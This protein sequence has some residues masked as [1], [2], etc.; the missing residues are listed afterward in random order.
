MLRALTTAATGM[1]AQQNNLHT[2]IKKS[3]QNLKIY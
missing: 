3:E 2:D 1:I